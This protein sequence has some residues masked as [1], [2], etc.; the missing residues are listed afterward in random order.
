MREI[1]VRPNK[2]GEEFKKFSMCLI[3]RDYIVLYYQRKNKYQHKS[4]Q[5]SLQFAKYLNLRT[6]QM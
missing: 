6:L 5:Y 2:W 3:Y 1:I 4:K